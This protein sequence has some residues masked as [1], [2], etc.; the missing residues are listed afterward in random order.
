MAGSGDAMMLAPSRNLN[1]RRHRHGM[2]LDTLGICFM[3]RHTRITFR[4]MLTVLPFALFW[5]S[6]G[7]A[8]EEGKTGQLLKMYRECVIDAIKTQVRN[9]HSELN[10]SAA[11]E[12]AF[13]ACRT[14]EQAILSHASA[15]GVTPNQANQVV[16]NY[17]LSLKQ[18]V[19][20]AFAAPEKYAPQP[21][22]P[23]T[24]APRPG[25]ASSYTRYDGATV[26][27]NCR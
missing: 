1:G 24:A 10:P 14:E 5:I 19:R 20:K 11:T 25:C 9:S 18:Q 27:T 4:G 15:G 23:Q 3:N 21:A 7:R 17:K 6:T 2:R 12:L 26:S 13:Q 8:Q 22:A 16:T